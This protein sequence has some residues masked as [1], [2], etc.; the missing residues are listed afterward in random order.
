MF[1]IPKELSTDLLSRVSALS[2]PVI[3]GVAIFHLLAFLYLRAWAGRDLRRM[4]SDFDSFTRELKHRSLLDRGTNLSDQIE[5][6]LADIRDVLDDP[7][8]KSERQALWHRM[9]I[10]DEER[11]YL[12]SHSFETCYNVCRSMV[13]AYPLAG[14]LG[15]VLAIGSAL[16]AGQTDAQQTLSDIVRFFGE[17]IWATFGG[18]MSAMILMFVNSIVEIKFMR[19]A[20]NRQHIRETIARAKRELSLVVGEET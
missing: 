3:V 7:A 4:A 10:L 15:T 2:T 14:V 6:F 18:L 17:A 11:R 20:E 12:Q 9:R 19:L 16:Q 1:S 5:A 13:E 8:K